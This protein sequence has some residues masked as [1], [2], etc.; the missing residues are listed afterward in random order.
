MNCQKCNS[1]ILP[2][3][4]SCSDSRFSESDNVVYAT[5]EE[6]SALDE[7]L[8]FAKKIIAKYPWK[9][10]V[11]KGFETRITEI[12]D[13]QNDRCLNLSVIVEFSSSK[14]S[15]INALLGE[16]LLVSSILQGTT[17]VNTL[18]EY[19]SKYEIEVL[20]NEETHSHIMYPIGLKELRGTLSVITT[21]NTDARRIQMVRVG[22]PS[23]LLRSGIRIID[24][25]G[26]NSLESWHEDV[27][28]KALRSISDVSVVLTDATRPL[29]ETLLAFMDENI[30]DIYAQCAIVATCID[31]VP[32]MERDS[33]MAYIKKKMSTLPKG[34]NALV[35][36]FCAPAVIGQR[37]GEI[38]IEKNQNEM[39][40]M[41]DKSA[42]DI[43]RHLSHQ[44]RIAQIK[45]LISLT[46]DLYNSLDGNM[47][48]QAES[49][50][51]ELD[52]LKRSKKA[53]LSEFIQ[54]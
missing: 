38:L 12:E 34:E 14:S 22:F 20:F 4:K 3:Q 16:E 40:A 2:G 29:P 27:T 25:P 5:L 15:F 45:K 32:K 21:D 43:Y 1:P 51:K 42:I 52:V 44:R 18:I 8:D 17:V 36:P 48:K 6:I 7:H 53:P 9:V 39:A 35:V 31:L 47:T 33:V 23:E 54:T 19:S 50:R 30:S 10:S 46:G 41:S 11:K 37:K 13:K 28:R 26:T 49:L 24:T